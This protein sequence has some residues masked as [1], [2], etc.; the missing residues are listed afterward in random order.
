MA[1]ATAP[2][3]VRKAPSRITF[4]RNYWLCR[5]EGFRVDSRHGPL[6]TVEELRFHSRVDRP[7]WLAVRTGGF[8]SRRMRMISVEYVAAVRPG[9][10]LVLLGRPAEAEAA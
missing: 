9:E 6:G 1:V 7:D 8:F 4:D 2:G 3:A 5:C 10:C